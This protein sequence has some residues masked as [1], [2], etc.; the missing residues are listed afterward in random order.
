MYL[1][2]SVGFHFNNYVVQAAV[3]WLGR[4]EKE[5]RE[6]RLDARSIAGVYCHGE[7]Q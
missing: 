3:T 4:R 1:I 7:N 6:R 5:R 2:S